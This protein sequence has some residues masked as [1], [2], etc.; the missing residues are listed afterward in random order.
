MA[1]ILLRHSK[2]RNVL[3]LEGGGNCGAC[4]EADGY[5]NHSQRF[6]SITFGR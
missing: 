2:M 6:W 3:L 4:V 5:R 1:S